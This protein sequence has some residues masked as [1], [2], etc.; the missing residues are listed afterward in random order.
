MHERGY[1]VRHTFYIDLDGK[2]SAIDREVKPA[3]SAEDM[4]AML[5]KLGVAL[6]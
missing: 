6:R 2:I 3:T 1:A 5:G 4:A